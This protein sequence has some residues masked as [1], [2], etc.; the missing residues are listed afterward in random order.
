MVLNAL[1]ALS[2][3]IIFTSMWISPVVISTEQTKKQAQGGQ[4]NQL[5]SDRA[6]I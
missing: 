2:C 1:H 5:V 6:G 3:L 4:V